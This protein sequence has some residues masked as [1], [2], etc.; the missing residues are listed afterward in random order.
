MASATPRWA[1]ERTARA[2]LGGAVADVARGLNVHL[3]PWQQTVVDVAYEPVDGSLAYRDVTLSTPRQSGKSTLLLAVIAHR[4]LATPDQV[5]VYGAQ[6]RAE[7]RKRLLDV[8]WPRIRRS[9]LRG[10]FEGVTRQIGAEAL[11]ACNGSVMYLLSSEESSG[12][13]D[14]VNLAV[15]DEG[16]SL[17]AHT[18]QAVRPSMVTKANAQLW[19]VSTAGTARSVWWRAKVDTGREAAEAGR[20]DAFAYFEWSAPADADPNDPEVWAA[21]MPALGETVDVD[22]VR[23]DQA[24]MPRGEFA[25]AYLNQWPDELDEHGWQVIDRHLWLGAKL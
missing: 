24:A 18:E 25:R 17:E 7:A 6:S 11:R 22:T 23:Q 4:L 20:S 13:G 9:R 8:W 3:L 14:T 2:T 15:L 12:H 1:T 10:A 16:W 5:V 21:A 19:C